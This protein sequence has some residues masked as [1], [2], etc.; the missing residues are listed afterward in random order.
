[1]NCVTVISEIRITIVIPHPHLLFSACRIH[2]VEFLS[3]Q[4][5]FEKSD[6][7]VVH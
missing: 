6:G 1:M 4:F 5:F 7:Q 3:E 2:C